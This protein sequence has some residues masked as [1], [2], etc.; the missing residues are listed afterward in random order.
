[1]D[2][3]SPYWSFGMITPAAPSA[4]ISPRNDTIARAQ[5]KEARRPASSR[6]VLRPVGSSG[7][8]PVVFCR[9]YGNAEVPRKA[10]TIR[11]SGRPSATE[12]ASAAPVGQHSAEAGVAGAEVAGERDLAIIDDFDG[13]AKRLRELRT[14]SPKSA[15]EI[16]ELEKWRDLARETA[17][18]YVENRRRGALSDY[19]PAVRRRS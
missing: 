11:G 10:S 7:D 9:Y 5:T 17:R 3:G 18:A 12:I 8:R 13:I 2:N 6:A 19:S 4:R 15:D 1:M 16:A 14:P